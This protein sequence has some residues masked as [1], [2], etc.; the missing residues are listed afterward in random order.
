MSLSNKNN[1]HSVM[2]VNRNI[3]SMIGFIAL[4]A[5]IQMMIGGEKSFS[6]TESHEIQL[7]RSQNKRS[8]DYQQEYFNLDKTNAFAK[9]KLP[10]D[11]Y[12]G[13]GP[14]IAILL[15]NRPQDIEE[16]KLALRSLVFLRG[17]HDPE[18]L[19]PVLIFNEG[20]LED[21]TIADLVRSTNRPIAFP[22]VDF[23]SFPPGFNPDNG[24][25]EFVVQGR[26]PWGYY[27][28]IR[29]WVTTIW[30]HP[31]INH[32]ETVMRLDTDSCFKA[33]NDYLP[34]FMDDDLYYHSLYVGVTGANGFK[35][36]KGLYD[37]TK[38]WL[39]NMRENGEPENPLFFDYLESK[40]ENENT[41]PLLRTNF[42]LSRRSFMQRADVMAFHEAITE[43][44]PFYLFQYRWGDAQIRLIMV[45][46]FMEKRR[47]MIER[48]DGYHHKARDGCTI[49]KVDDA[50]RAN[51]LL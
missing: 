26:N 14:V 22:V 8:N 33:T 6:G 4:L 10:L 1:K 39:K 12:P 16:L 35:Y 5:L 2:I 50:M 51:N 15:A 47:V 34:N 20:D 18:H 32:F 40:W 29:F 21:V 3:L 43:K 42:E 37:F 30:K 13:G 28:M 36:I 44:E 25:P 41:L 23:F 11:F 17:D 38:N 19:A 49:E 27:Q 9:K 7:L 46:L 48:V 31:V 24:A 45:A